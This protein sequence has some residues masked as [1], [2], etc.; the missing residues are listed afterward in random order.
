MERRRVFS[1]N[2]SLTLRF[3]LRLLS[4]ISP[5]LQE[6]RYLR[7]ASDDPLLL[8]FWSPGLEG[9]Q[10]ARHCFDEEVIDRVGRLF[11][12]HEVVNIGLVLIKRLLDSAWHFGPFPS[13]RPTRIHGLS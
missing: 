10:H 2:L 12:V 4:F 9:L 7:T 11:G 1:V 5:L 8:I 3:S 13:S 6:L